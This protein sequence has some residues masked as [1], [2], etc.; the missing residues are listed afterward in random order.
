[1]ISA[2]SALLLFLGAAAA[3]FGLLANSVHVGYAGLFL[4]IIGV[5][6]GI[7]ALF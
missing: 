7:R 3:V 5:G 1:M 2:Y 4:G 6:L